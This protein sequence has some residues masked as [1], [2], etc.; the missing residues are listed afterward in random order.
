MSTYFGTYHWLKKKHYHPIVAGGLAGLANWTLTYPLDVI[1]SRVYGQHIGMVEA[2]RQGYL[3][4]GYSFCAA[5]AIMVNATG[6][7]VYEECKR[8]ISE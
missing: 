1:R 5:R 4:R 3:W 7:Y 6:F 2:Y 8:Y